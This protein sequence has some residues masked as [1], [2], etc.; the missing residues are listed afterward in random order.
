ML[1]T[2]PMKHAGQELPLDTT[3][4]LLSPRPTGLW[5]Q[6]GCGPQNENSWWH[7]CRETVFHKL[8]LTQTYSNVCVNFAYTQDRDLGCRRTSL[9]WKSDNRM[10]RQW[11]RNKAEN[12]W[13]R[14]LKTFVM[15]SSDLTIKPSLMFWFHV[16]VLMCF[17]LLK[18]GQQT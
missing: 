15:S 5:P 13:M 2:L 18:H 17:M 10:W 4:G 3:G 12:R 7:R 6:M 8:Q 11:S 16:S 9:C 14:M 1:L